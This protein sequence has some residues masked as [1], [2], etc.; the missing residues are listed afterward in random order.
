MRLLIKANS[1][2]SARTVD[3]GPTAPHFAIQGHST[4]VSSLQRLKPPSRGSIQTSSREFTLPLIVKL[5]EGHEK[6]LRYLLAARADVSH[7]DKEGKNALRWAA[8]F[9]CERFQKNCPLLVH[10]ESIR[11][12]FYEYHADFV[13]KDNYG[14][15]PL[16]LC[17]QFDTLTDYEKNNAHEQPHGIAATE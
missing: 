15:T 2:V 1:D 14:R 13:A 11:W 3:G 10:D 8:E 16:Q 4:H 7:R 12:L 17:Y 5:D 6:A 9:A